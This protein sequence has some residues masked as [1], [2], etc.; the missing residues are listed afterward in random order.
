VPIPV[1]TFQ[2]LRLSFICFAIFES[3]FEQGDELQFWDHEG[4]CIDYT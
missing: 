4:N 1:A 3:F 2:A